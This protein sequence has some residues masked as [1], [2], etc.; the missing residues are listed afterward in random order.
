MIFF[1]DEWPDDEWRDRLFGAPALVCIYCDQGICPNDSGVVM[2]LVLGGPNGEPEV[3]SCA[4][5]RKCL[6]VSLGIPPHRG[7]AR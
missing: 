5:H 3:S 2:P 6:F 1:G 7:A 4:Y